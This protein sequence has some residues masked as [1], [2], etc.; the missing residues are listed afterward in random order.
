LIIDNFKN[1]LRYERGKVFVESW[2]ILGIKLWV[3]GKDL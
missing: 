2:A 3:A 1:I